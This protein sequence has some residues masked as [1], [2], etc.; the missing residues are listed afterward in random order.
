IFDDTTLFEV[1]KFSGYDRIE[2]GTR[3]NVGLQYTFQA[4]NGGY[5][6]LVAGQ[7]FHLAGENP[8]ETPGT[9]FD[10]RE[11]YSSNSGLESTRS[12]YVVGAYLSPSS[13]F[14]IVSQA[15]FDEE[16]LSLRRTDVGAQIDL[17]PFVAQG[18]YTFSTVDPQLLDDDQQDVTFGVGL[19]LT[20][21]W[22]IYGNMRYDIDAKYRIS[23]SIQI[24]YSDECFI[25][26]ATYLETFIRDADR[27]IV[28]DRSVMLNFQFKHL[29]GYQ[30]KTDALDFVFG[31][32]QRSSN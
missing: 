20:D 19:K 12:D 28:P 25:L 9:S 15:R 27:D 14:R 17:G 32:Q 8:F 24:A 5:A 4:N 22:S 26:T 21:R 31:D 18:S 10:G 7:S 1:D 30:T 6:R 23:D 29:G 13:L 2:T 11:N 3:A 16:T